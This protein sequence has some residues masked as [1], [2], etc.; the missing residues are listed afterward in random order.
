MICLLIKS[1]LY[2]AIFYCCQLE[3]DL[4]V[5]FN[6]KGKVSYLAPNVLILFLL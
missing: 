1:L 4:V 6:E 2:I 3:N 5:S